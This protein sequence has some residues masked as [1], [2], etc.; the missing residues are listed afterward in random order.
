MPGGS[1]PILGTIIELARMGKVNDADVFAQATGGRHLSFETLKGLEET[2][3]RAGED[4]HSQYL[5]SFVPRSSSGGF[6]RVAVEVPS[7]PDAVVRARPG[8]WGQ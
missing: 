7:H 3:A 2:I 6:H 5:L 4:I 8:Y 1:G